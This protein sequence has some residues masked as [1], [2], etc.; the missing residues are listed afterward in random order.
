MVQY[1][2]NADVDWRAVSR[3]VSASSILPREDWLS[4]ILVW[5][6]ILSEV[7][8]AFDY[9]VLSPDCPLN[10]SHHQALVDTQKL[11]KATEIMGRYIILC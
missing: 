6:A 7:S 9:E 11:Y 10:E 1:S 2:D 5:H 8:L 4:C 3:A